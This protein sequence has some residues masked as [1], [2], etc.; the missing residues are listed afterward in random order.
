MIFMI[1]ITFILFNLYFLL[2]AMLYSPIQLKNVP[3]PN[4]PYSEM[5]IENETSLHYADLAVAAHRLSSNW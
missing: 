3:V 5:R 4:F 2:N 1:F